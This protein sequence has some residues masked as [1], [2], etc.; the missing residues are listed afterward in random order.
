MRENKCERL[1]SSKK[2]RRERR[3]EDAE[4]YVRKGIIS[5]QKTEQDKKRK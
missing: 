1:R 3:K 4:K 5:I 2:E